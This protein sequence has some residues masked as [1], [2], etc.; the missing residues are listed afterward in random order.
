MTTSSDSRRGSGFATNMLGAAVALCAYFT[1]GMDWISSALLFLPVRGLADRLLANDGLG[2]VKHASIMLLFPLVI[3]IS[4]ILT[5]KLLAYIAS[6][7]GKTGA[8]A[9][10]VAGAC[11]GALVLVA[12]YGIASLVA[13]LFGSFSM[14]DKIHAGVVYAVESTARVLVFAFGVALVRYCD[15]RFLAISPPLKM[16]LAVLLGA[17]VIFSLVRLFRR[18]PLPVAARDTG[19]AAD[20]VRVQTRPT[21]R[22]A[23]VIGMDDAKEQIR[24]RLIEPV[25]N[26]LKARKYGLS[27]GGGVLLY[28]P[29]GT[30]KTML[31]RGVAGELN[32]PFF[33]I[34]A[35]D[36]FGKYVGESERNMRGIFAEIRKHRLSVLF[37]DELETLFPNRSND[38]HE[39]TRK[40]I[41]VILQ[42]LDGL[43]KNKN[44]I[45]LLGATN[46]PWMVD[47]AFLRPGRFDIKIFVGLPDERARRR[48]IATAFSKG[49][50]PIEDGLVEFMAAG[51]N[52]YS[53]ADLNGVMD[54]LRQLAYASGAKFYGRALAEKAIASVS[55]TANG[56]ILDKIQDWEAQAMPSNSRN[57]GSSGVRI[58]ARPDVTLAD[59]AGMDAAKEEIRL[60][61]LEP[62]RNATIAGHYGLR[63]GGGML[64]YG[65]PGT[66]KTFMARAV[67]G[68]LGLPFYAISSADIFG[69]YI[70]ESERN[71][72]KIFRDIRKNELSVV[73][74][75]ELET[76]FPKRTGDVHETTR[77][78]ISLL[79][80]ELDGLDDGKNPI[81]LIGATNVPWMVDEAFLRPGRFDVCIYI[82]P[83]DSAARKQM[84]CRALE[85][86]EVPYEV[87]LDEYI[88]KQ[89]EGFTGA[90]LK[91]L[92]E[93]MRQF[94][95]KNRLRHYTTATADT[96]LSDFTPSR[97]DELVAQIRQ[98]EATR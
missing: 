23:D 38:V 75:D 73:F 22:L 42:E 3:Q 87:G 25:R 88:A 1:F 90:D 39:T 11:V 91:G 84:V 28:G 67:A 29:P 59:V 48:M 43:D 50:V 9:T 4:T 78:V 55:P 14:P 7:G 79:L 71:I 92:I 44:P 17:G 16:A 70:G 47:E 10:M 74:I 24:L 68:E 61:L 34:T 98:W 26:P 36:V 15:G 54:R 12:A 31:A 52:N 63:A 95:F 56:E 57:S 8:A 35:A 37:I 69:K 51:T 58:S 32:L 94:A 64:L 85:S 65:P 45:L 82:G 2:I 6:G 96:V 49:S 80:Q 5:G 30:G 77:K 66:G 81:L 18:G 62:V 76:L 21:A 83:P 72:K 89:T 97:N 53:G 20:A 13:G 60:R 27:V 33:M 40:V 46:V 93:R 41:S 19:G 86:G